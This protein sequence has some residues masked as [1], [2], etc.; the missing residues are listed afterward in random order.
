VR[1]VIDTNVLLSALLWHGAP[2]ALIEQV[3]GGAFTLVS[4]PALLAELADVISRPKFDAILA[5]SSTSRNRVLAEVRQLAEVVAPLPLPA[6]VCRDPDDDALLALAVGAQAELIV[7][8]DHDL[9][10]LGSYAGIPIVGA[11]EAMRR[12]GGLKT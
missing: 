8:G 5:R 2:H 10:A 3:R 1:A 12:I 7:S 9:L 4:S 11:A 6:P